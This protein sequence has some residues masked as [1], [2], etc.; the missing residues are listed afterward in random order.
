MSDTRDD[1]VADAAGDA[2]ASGRAGRVAL[3]VIAALTV[4]FAAVV[5]WFAGT[6]ADGPVRLY[7][8]VAVAGT[9]PALATAG[10]AVTGGLLA[11]FGAAVVAASRAAS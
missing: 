3:G 6:N 2:T 5:G 1:G 4:G 7:G 8:V 10:V 11:L 9:P